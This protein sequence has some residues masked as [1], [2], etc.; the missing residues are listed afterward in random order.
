VPVFAARGTEDTIHP[1]ERTELL[2]RYAP[3]ADLLT[4][5]GAGHAITHGRTEDVL[6]GYRRF[7]RDSAR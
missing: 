5:D 4:L 2:Q 1:D 3:Q 6:D 7:V